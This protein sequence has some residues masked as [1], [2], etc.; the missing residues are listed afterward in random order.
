MSEATDRCEQLREALT[1]CEGRLGEALGQVLMTCRRLLHVCIVTIAQVAEL[2]EKA[3]GVRSPA[4]TSAFKASSSPS[5]SALRIRYSALKHTCSS[6]FN[7]LLC[8]QVPRVYCL[9]QASCSLPIS[10]FAAA[11]NRDG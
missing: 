2:Q 3:K 5:S 4:P 9:G 6:R 8:L 10:S 7:F 1:K 11:Q